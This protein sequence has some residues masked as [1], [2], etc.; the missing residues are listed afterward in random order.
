MRERRLFGDTVWYESYLVI[1]M[2]RG[3]WSVKRQEKEAGGKDPTLEGARHRLGGSGEWK[4]I[5]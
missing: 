1:C 5:D 2:K 3:D 4:G